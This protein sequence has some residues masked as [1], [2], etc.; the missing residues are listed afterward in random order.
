MFEDAGNCVKC[1]RRRRQTQRADK[2]KNQ[3]RRTNTHRDTLTGETTVGTNDLG[4][5]KNAKDEKTQCE[6]TTNVHTRMRA[7]RAREPAETCTME[8]DGHIE[9]ALA[10]AHTETD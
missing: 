9:A 6:P 3:E 7:T 8:R 10:A 5:R 4:P 2:R 1:W